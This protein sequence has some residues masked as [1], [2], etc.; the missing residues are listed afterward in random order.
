[1]KKLLYLFCASLLIL[2]SCSK[3]DSQD[4]TAD[5]VVLVKKAISNNGTS[6]DFLEYGYSGKK[7]TRITPSIAG[8]AFFDFSYDGDLI[9]GSK[10]Y[11]GDN[12][13][14]FEMVYEYDSKQRLVT[15]K[16]LSK[17]Y[18]FGEKKVFV[19]NSDGTIG[20]TKFSGDLIKQDEIIGT[21]TIWLNDEGE[22]IKVEEYQDDALLSRTEYTYDDKKC[23][24]NNIPAYNKLFLLG[25]IAKTHNILTY[26]A[27]DNNNVLAYSYSN[28]YAYNTAN[29]PVSVITTFKDGTV[30][31]TDWIYY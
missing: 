1:M 25:E 24:F 7:L 27:Y 30:G 23:I 29:Y 6:T 8:V 21:G 20:F 31:T 3:D 14:D 17:V 18:S 22:T 26:K 28:K 19:Y 9:N 13:V 16:T 11:N 15:E 10:R 12:V 2:T 5:N 4:S